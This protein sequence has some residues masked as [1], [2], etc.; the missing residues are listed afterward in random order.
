MIC[1]N[2]DVISVDVETP[3]ESHSP[4]SDTFLTSGADGCLNQHDTKNDDVFEHE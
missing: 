4:I 3:K 2:N 1:V